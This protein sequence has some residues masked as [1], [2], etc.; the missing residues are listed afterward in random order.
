MFLFSHNDV[1]DLYETDS[2]VDGP[3]YDVTKIQFFFNLEVLQNCSNVQVFIYSNYHIN[4][5]YVK[6]SSRV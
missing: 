4:T 6:C 1:D 5:I 2:I 3:N